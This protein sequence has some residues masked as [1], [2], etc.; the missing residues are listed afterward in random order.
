MEYQVATKHNRGWVVGVWREM[1]GIVIIIITMTQN[2]ELEMRVKLGAGCS[3][4]G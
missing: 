1:V 2:N 3:S 4:P